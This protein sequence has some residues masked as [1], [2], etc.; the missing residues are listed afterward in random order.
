MIEP[1]DG[2]RFAVLLGMGIALAF[3]G[4]IM[5]GWLLWIVISLLRDITGKIKGRLQWTRK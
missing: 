3:V 1:G 5:A 4:P 2:K